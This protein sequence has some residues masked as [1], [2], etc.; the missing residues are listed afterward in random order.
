MSER[1]YR[2][3]VFLAGEGGGEKGGGGGIVNEG[4]I[5]YFDLGG[6]ENSGLSRIDSGKN[7]RIE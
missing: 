7:D 2:V 4:D 1:G 6:K 5:L 3:C